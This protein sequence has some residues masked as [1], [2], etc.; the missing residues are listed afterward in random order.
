MRDAWKEESQLREREKAKSGKKRFEVAVGSRSEVG[1]WERESRERE[2]PEEQ[3]KFRTEVKDRE[4]AVV[5]ER[6]CLMAWFR[7][8]CRLCPRLHQHSPRR[9]KPCWLRYAA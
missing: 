9:H 7:C 5:V 1:G 3:Q 4:A 2:R 8:G 6:G